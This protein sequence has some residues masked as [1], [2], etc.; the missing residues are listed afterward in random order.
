MSHFELS[1]LLAEAKRILGTQ[2]PP[3]QR[4]LYSGWKKRAKILLARLD[5]PPALVLK[6]ERLTED[7]QLL[8]YA[9]ASYDSPPNHS[10]KGSSRDVFVVYGRNTRLRDSM[11]AFLRSLQLNPIEWSVAVNRTAAG[12]PYVG[13][14]LHETIANVPAVVVLMTP[15]DEAKLRTEFVSPTDP[16][17]ERELTPQAR[18]NVLFEAGMAFA[19]H[20]E[21]TILLE[22]GRNLRP[23]SDVAGRHVIRMDNSP[24]KRHELL[25][26][27]KQANCPV[28]EL[29]EDWLSM[30][31][32]SSD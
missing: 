32:F 6:F 1:S 20:P 10:V 26:R 13:Q 21:K 12:S 17:H 11:F 3:R 8:K 18:P 9:L 22:I 7:V 24:A 14:V 15:D 27:L 30:G 25:G 5:N 16:V 19:L 31:D 23:F 28:E 29:G 2:N 4:D